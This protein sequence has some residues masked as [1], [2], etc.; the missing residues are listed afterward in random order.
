VK[1][2][3]KKRQ[4]KHPLLQPLKLLKPNSN[5]INR[6]ITSSFPLDGVLVMFRLPAGLLRL[7]ARSLSLSAGLLR[8]S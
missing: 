6:D 1:P 2:L 7:P 3:K 5:P 4:P 8:L